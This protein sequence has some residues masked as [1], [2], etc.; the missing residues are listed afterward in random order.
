MLAF[1]VKVAKG[2]AQR[3]EV[4]SQLVSS[5]FDLAPGANAHMK[6]GCIS[7]GCLPVGWQRRGRCH[8]SVWLKRVAD[9]APRRAT[10]QPAQAAHAFLGL[11][12]R[13]QIP[14]WKQCVN[15]VLEILSLLHQHPH[16]TLDETADALEER[17]EAPPEGAEVGSGGGGCHVL[18]CSFPLVHAGWPSPS[19]HV[20]WLLCPASAAAVSCSL[21]I[22]LVSRGMG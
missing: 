18:P 15:H 13:L 3:L 7:A 19:H 20:P 22:H 4:L 12:L 6:V 9:P 11:S 5:L 16:I 1:L 10:L 8:A 2:A 21:L 17:S 14:V